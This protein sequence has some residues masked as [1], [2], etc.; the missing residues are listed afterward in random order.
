[1]AESDEL[2]AAL[3]ASDLRFRLDKAEQRE[4]REA[5][6][7]AERRVARAALAAWTPKQ[8]KHLFGAAYASKG[9]KEWREFCDSLVALRDLLGV[10]LTRE[11]EDQR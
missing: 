4:K 9:P 10:S 8:A 5:I 1:M 6:Q 7:K 3:L 2:A 11:S